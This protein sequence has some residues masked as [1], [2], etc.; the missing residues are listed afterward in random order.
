MN[1]LEQQRLLRCRTE[2][3]D[4]GQKEVLIINCQKEE[5]LLINN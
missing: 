2:Q 1:K 3:F 4:C 5:N